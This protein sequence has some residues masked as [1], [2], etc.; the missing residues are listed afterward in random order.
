MLGRPH[1]WKEIRH[2]QSLF[3]LEYERETNDG[4]LIMNYWVQFLFKLKYKPEFRERTSSSCGHFFSFSLRTR[5]RLSVSPLRLLSPLWPIGNWRKRSISPTKFAHF[6]CKFWSRQLLRFF[7]VESIAKYC[8]NCIA[9][10]DS[11]NLRVHSL[12]LQREQLP[13][14]CV[15]SDHLCP[16]HGPPVILSLHWCRSDHCAHEAV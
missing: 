4:P 5:W 14:P 6:N 13:L 1:D 16:R 10:A 2:Y 7:V 9:D 11:R 8:N 12:L 3:R 15:L